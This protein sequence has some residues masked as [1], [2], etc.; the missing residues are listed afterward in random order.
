MIRPTT[1]ALTLAIA[2]AVGLVAACGRTPMERQP[3]TL[4]VGVQ[5]NPTVLD[6]RLA[7]DVASLHV[8][9]LVYNRLIKKDPI[10]KL[11]CDLCTRWEQ[12]DPKTY[13]FYL[14]RGVRFHDGRELTAEDVVYTF[15]SMRDP[16]LQS[17]RRMS[18]EPVASVRAV[19]RYTVEFRLKELY[20]PFLQNVTAAIV[21]KH[22]AEGRP[23]A[24]VREPIGTGPFR[25]VEW[26]PD[27]YILLEAFPDY[28][29]GPAK[30]ERVMLKVI[31]DQTVRLLELERGGVDLLINLVP[32]DSLP[33]LERNSDL[34]I[35]SRPGS[36]FSYIGFNLEDAVLRRRLVRQAIAHAIDRRGIILNI[37][38]GLATLARGLLP[39]TH[40]AYEPDVH[41]YHYDPE[42]ARR[43]LD[44][45]G[46]P[47]PP[48]PEPRLT[49]VYKTSMNEVRRRIGEVLQAQLAEVGIRVVIKNYEWGTFYAD[50]RRGNFQMYTLTWVG[51]TD[52][53]HY[54]YIYHSSSLP[55]RGAN[56]N[57][58]R[59]PELDK[60]LDQG[61]GTID[62]AARRSIYGRV[63]RIVADDLPYVPLWHALNVAVMRRDLKGFVLYANQDFSG[64]KGA[65]IDRGEATPTTAGR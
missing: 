25:F 30:I 35:V 37:L 10:G 58:Y 47:D 62:P 7:M 61:R 1:A 42:E 64:L 16:A 8:L 34:R 59:N 52:P 14:H 38:K 43:L 23:E 9:Q 54:Y 65:Y 22:H 31:P 39:P 41:T 36:S 28:W 57:R 40:W 50:I 20:A 53:D 56:R 45:A 44:E 29:E 13:R 21:P 11:V 5:T 4:I 32:P 46:L 15:R 6:P 60:L 3:G 48:G 19:G 49:I 26:R 17:P 33:R 27:E 18:M 63:Q 2:L 51:I 12:P 24:V 55:P